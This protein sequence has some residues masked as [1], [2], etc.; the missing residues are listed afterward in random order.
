VKVA[1]TPARARSDPGG[2]PAM[3]L[4]ITGRSTLLADN[5][6]LSRWRAGNHHQLTKRGIQLTIDGVAT[7][8]RNSG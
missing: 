8:L 6:A 5:P 4:A 1:R 2:Q 7:A 3:V